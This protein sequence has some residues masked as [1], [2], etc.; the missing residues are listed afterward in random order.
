MNYYSL[1]RKSPKTTFK[2][3]VVEGLAKDRGIYFPETITPLSKDFI[4]NIENYSN[5]EIAFEV[6]KQFVG[7]EIPTEKLKEIIEETVSFDFPVVKIT[8]NIASLELFHGPTMAFKDVG[9]KFMAKCLEYFNQGNDKEVTVLVATSGD[10]GGAVAN[11]FLGVKGVNVVILYPSGKVSDIQE[12]Q[13][14]TLGQNITALE[15]DGVFDDCQ[16]MVKTAFLDEEISRTLTSANSINVARWLPQMFYFFF[17]YK[18]LKKLNKELVFSVPSGNFGNICAGVMAQKLGLPIKH[19][20]AS[21]NV[22]DTVPNYLKDGKYTPK[23]SK[24]TISNAMDVGNPSNFIRIQ[25]LYNNDFEA[26]KKHFSSYSFSDYETREKMK[27]IYKESGYVADPH[28]AVGYLGLEKY[29]LNENE[30]G[31][32]LETAHPVKFLDVVEETLPVKV[33]IPEQIQ[34][35][36]NNKKVAIKASSYEDLKAFLMK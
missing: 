26:L 1:H 16:E 21:T 30:F 32:F 17:T 27:A 25:E 8:D 4:E 15:V 5:Q 2:N 36:I 3:A 23:P 20:V 31:V 6:I 33:K 11:G 10:T 24:A 22:N 34:K 7:D 14:T 9:A 18:E 29:G 13:L 12:K 35:V 28:G 19:F